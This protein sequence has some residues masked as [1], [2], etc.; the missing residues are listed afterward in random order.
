MS[1]LSL[2]GVMTP[3]NLI[4]HHISVYI[5]RCMS[6]AELTDRENEIIKKAKELNKPFQWWEVQASP[7]DLSKLVIKGI[8]KVTG[9]TGSC[10]TYEVVPT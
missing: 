1:I 6:M 3:T 8:I 10:N 2:L 9:K 5:Y 7:M 4:K